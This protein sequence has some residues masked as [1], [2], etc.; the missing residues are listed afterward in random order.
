VALGSDVPLAGAASGLGSVELESRL[1]GG[2]WLA[3]EPVAPSASGAFSVSVTPSQTTRYRLSAGGALGAVVTVAVAATVDATI[4]SGEVTGSVSPALAGEAVVLQ[5]ADGPRWDTVVSGT[6][7]P[8]GGFRIAAPLTPGTYRVRADP[9]G[10]LR[11]GFSLPL[12][13]AAPAQ[14]PASSSSSSGT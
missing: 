10:G 12:T 5:R 3:L 8:G 9:G 7:A 6:T 2:T 14:L 1:P 13:A 11:P 4:G